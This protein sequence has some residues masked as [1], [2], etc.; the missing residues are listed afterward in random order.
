MASLLNSNRAAYTFIGS[1]TRRLFIAFKQYWNDTVCNAMRGL[2]WLVWQSEVLHVQTVSWV[3][4]AAG[5]KLGIHTQAASCRNTGDMRQPIS[6]ALLTSLAYI[7][8]AFQLQMLVPAA[9][10]AEKQ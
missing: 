1:K 7:H 9:G 3:F 5:I 6:A 8:D 2:L 10:S 4:A